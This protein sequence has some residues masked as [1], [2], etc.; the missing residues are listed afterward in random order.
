MLRT[1]A[2]CALAGALLV[3]GAA[4]ADNKSKAPAKTESKQPKVKTYNFGGLD[5]EGRLRTPQLLYF[6]NRMKSEFD[7]TT[8]DKRSFI[9]ELKRTGEEMP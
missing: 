9:P 2:S 6:L 4:R 1:F 7:T 8:P 5:V 3:G